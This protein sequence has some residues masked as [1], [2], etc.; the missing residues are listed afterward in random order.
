VL[1][2]LTLRPLNASNE[3]WSTFV[4]L[5][6]LADMP[7]SDLSAGGRFFAV[8]DDMGLVGFGGLEGSGADQLLRS[9]VVA[10]GLRRRGM[11]P[12]VVQRLVEQAQREGADR[13]WLLTTQADRFFASLGWATVTRNVAPASVQTSR[14]YSEI[15]PATAVLMVRSL[16]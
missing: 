12:I 4:S 7:T 6:A 3:V 11:G 1:T 16:A 15:C 2:A 14:L 10:P 8:E 5:L 9:V 13:L